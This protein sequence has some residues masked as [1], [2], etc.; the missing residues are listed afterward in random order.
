MRKLPWILVI[1][2]LGVIGYLLLWEKRDRPTETEPGQTPSVFEPQISTEPDIILDGEE[3]KSISEE[4]EYLKINAR[5]PAFKDKG[6]SDYIVRVIREEISNFRENSGIDKMSQS[7]K[8]FI[9]QSGAKYEFNTTYKIYETENVASVV[10][11]ISTYTGGA[12][13][14]LVVRSLNFNRSTENLTIGDLFEPGSNYLSK[15]SEISRTKL[16][17]NLKENLG[18]WSDDGTTPISKNFETFY[19]TEGKLHIIFQPYQVAPWVAGAPEITIDLETELKDVI[20]SD[21]IN[22]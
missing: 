15:L 17:A 22:E 9:F 5:Y 16:R 19:L 7:D 11:D 20:S 3:E 2:L 14:G 4:T 6:K 21:F 18:N 1:V 13:G 10:F 8:D 12:H